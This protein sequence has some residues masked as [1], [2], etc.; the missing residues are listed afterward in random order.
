[1]GS[2]PT[3]IIGFG[4]A[5][6][7]EDYDK[8]DS[9]FESAMAERLETKSYTELKSKLEEINV[10]VELDGSLEG[11]VTRPYLMIQDWQ[12]RG[13]WD[14][15]TE[16]NPAKFFKE[17]TDLLPKWVTQLKMVCDFLGIKYE[18]PKVLMIVNYG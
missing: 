15:P 4:F 6:S 13:S 5:I 8:I 3:A 14:D 7:D 11:G 17:W 9:D 18:E 1:M 2:D 12:I 10:G 16:I